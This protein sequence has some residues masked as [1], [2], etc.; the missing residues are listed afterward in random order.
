MTK[1]S[2]NSFHED[3]PITSVDGDVLG[4]SQLA[5]DLAKRIASQRP[6]KT[7][8]IAITGEWG[9]GKSSFL[10]LLEH[11]L[12][13]R[14][15]RWQRCIRRGKVVRFAPP[16]FESTQ[17]L[18]SL[19]AEQITE[20]A[21]WIKHP[22]RAFL[23]G[24]QRHA[25]FLS[26]FTAV[27]ALAIFCV[28]TWCEDINPSFAK[29]LTRFDTT[30]FLSF[31]VF[32]ATAQLMKRSPQEE[33]KRLSGKR[34][35]FL[36]GRCKPPPQIVF[37]DELDRWNGASVRE[38]INFIKI[39]TTLSNKIF[40]LAFDKDVVAQHLTENGVSGHDYLEKIIQYELKLP[41][42]GGWT[43]R[44][45]LDGKLR[46]VSENEQW[47][48]AC[49]GGRY[50]YIL[51]E[52][53][54]AELRTMRDVHRYINAVS[55]SAGFAI[56]DLDI[57]D[58]LLVELLKLKHADVFDDLYAYKRFLTQDP[59][60]ASNIDELVES[61][62]FLK[63]MNETKG[64]TAQMSSFTTCLA[65]L[66]PT[67][68]PLILPAS[69]EGNWVRPYFIPHQRTSDLLISDNQFFD[70]YFTLTVAP[71]Q[72]SDLEIEQAL[73][74]PNKE[75]A[76]R[77]HIG[78]PINF[79]R[80]RYIV[81]RLNINSTDHLNDLIPALL[82]FERVIIPSTYNKTRRSVSGKIIWFSGINDENDFI[83]I[84]VK[85]MVR[86]IA[87]SS[88]QRN[89]VIERLTRETSHIF[90][91]ILISMTLE[92]HSVIKFDD[93]RLFK[94]TIC[95]KIQE[96]FHDHSIWS[97][98][99]T[100]FIIN[101]WL[102]ESENEDVALQIR[103][104]IVDDANFLKVYQALR[105]QDDSTTGSREYFPLEDFKMIFE[106]KGKILSRLREIAANR[107]SLRAQAEELLKQAAALTVEPEH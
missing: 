50:D 53:L 64:T 90:L 48:K 37:I 65:C 70:R 92:N 104:F 4:R 54:S 105:T 74:T 79:S 18:L 103:D 3:L 66:F 106:S 68:K 49:R 15:T 45:L 57:H 30:L 98:H 95:I 101:F 16:Y 44:E 107:P 99:N 42:I 20:R 13:E 62:S 12:H 28:Q 43:L 84:L 76:F 93:I 24:L 63:L 97:Q 55:F 23:A 19:L 26:I 1:K 46:N 78:S 34:G 80:I 38:L 77:K 14:R 17:D 96:K 9:S 8:I 25:F 102:C 89:E 73:K 88:T 47:Q 72:I 6:E 75:E 36:G 52:I 71:D 59:T 56:Q 33:I 100:S 27:I 40:I 91:L 94:K 22:W 2:S 32:F 10:N 69:S 81:G 85:E 35:C 41:T 60:R 51:D 58:Y 61:S 39:N 11:E 21:R 82:M 86:A 5:Q 87:S 7:L 83:G 67:I 31:L 29:A